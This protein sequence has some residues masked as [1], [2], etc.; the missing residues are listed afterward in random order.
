VEAKYDVFISYSSHDAEFA[1]L[2]KD[3]LVS[4][5]MRVWLDQDEIRPGDLFVEALETGVQASRAVT[6]IVSQRAIESKWVREEFYR[7]LQMCHSYGTRLIPILISGAIPPGFLLS[8]QCIDFRKGDEFS[9][10]MESLIWGISGKTKDKSGRVAPSP[11]SQEPVR[12]RIEDDYI[13]AYLLDFSRW[14]LSSLKN[15]ALIGTGVYDWAE[16]LN[17]TQSQIII[18]M[19]FCVLIG[20]A[21]GLITPYRG[22]MSALLVIIAATSTMA[23]FVSSMIQCFCLLLGGKGSANRTIFAVMQVL[24]IIYTISNFSA[25]I[26]TTILISIPFPYSLPISMGPATA[27]IPLGSIILLVS[28]FLLISVYIPLSL[29]GVHNFGQYK[30][31]ADPRSFLGKVPKAIQNEPGQDVRPKDTH[32]FFRAVALSGLGAML[33]T[34]AIL[35]GLGLISSIFVIFIAWLLMHGGGC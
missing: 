1:S 20:Y 34:I 11:F 3:A 2:L 7:A 15:P 25:L 35:V 22:P 28:Q 13:Q 23:L 30:K 12:S 21:L 16:R 10:N 26:F 6:L 33:G 24:A 14:F 32:R 8:R 27:T 31:T 29:R 18:F 4:K 17:P 9:S 5:G 19:L